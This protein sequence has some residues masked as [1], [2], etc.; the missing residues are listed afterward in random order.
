[1]NV[2]AMAWIGGNIT[3]AANTPFGWYRITHD[4]HNNVTAWWIGKSKGIQPDWE[5]AKQRA[6][7]DFEG[8]VMECFEVP[9]A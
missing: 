1:M 5:T 2:K 3:V 8:R 7:A 9:P 4:K 6:Q